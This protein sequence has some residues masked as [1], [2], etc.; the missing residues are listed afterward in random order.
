MRSNN[1]ILPQTEPGNYLYTAHVFNHAPS[2][3]STS[4]AQCKVRVKDEV[5]RIEM[6][7][8]AVQFEDGENIAYVASGRTLTMTVDVIGGGNSSVVDWSV[9]SNNAGCDRRAMPFI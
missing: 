7:Y 6:T 8:P 5:E 3:C 9:T 1:V 2:D 4:Q